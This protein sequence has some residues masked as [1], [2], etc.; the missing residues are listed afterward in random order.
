MGEKKAS[1]RTSAR[2]PSVVTAG[3]VNLCAPLFGLSRM[4]VAVSDF[5]GDAYS[6]TNPYSVSA[7]TRKDP[8]ALEPTEVYTAGPPSPD[9][10]A[11]LHQQL[12]V[13]LPM[14]DCTE[15]ADGGPSC[16]D[17][18]ASDT[19]VQGR[20]SYTYDQDW[21][22]YIHPCPLED[23]MVKIYYDFDEG[24]TDIY[25]QVFLYNNSWFDN[26]SD[27]VD[28]ANQ[29]AKTGYFGGLDP[30]DYCFYA[31]HEHQGDPFWYYLSVRDTIFVSEDEVENGTWDWSPD[32]VYRIC[33]EKA[34]S[35]CVEPPC[36]IYD[37]GCGPPEDE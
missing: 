8:D 14:H 34:A 27:T 1:P 3:K 25:M 12:A 20:L 35:T 17:P 13:E 16:C 32:Q 31:F 29:P 2:G 24:P 11:S 4:F 37:N 22:K 18:A 5:H 36:K 9:D 19:W 23:C 21:Y 7:R 30:K 6:L 26:L 10:D 15:E 33:V 28:L